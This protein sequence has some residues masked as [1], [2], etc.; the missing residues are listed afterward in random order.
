MQSATRIDLAYQIVYVKIIKLFLN[1][2]IKEKKRNESNYFRFWV[3]IFLMLMFWLR[4]KKYSFSYKEA[5][6]GL[7]FIYARLSKQTLHFLR[8]INV[9]NVH[10]VYGAGI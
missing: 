6:P 1:L 3:K 4:P 8:Q 5:F 10:P 9:K 7:F 2:E